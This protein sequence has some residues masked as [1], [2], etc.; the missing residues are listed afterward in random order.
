M[1]ATS[2]QLKS[3]V[4]ALQ[5]QLANLARSQAK[6]DRLRG[7]ASTSHKA[8]RA[9][10]EKGFTGLKLALEILH[11]YYAGDQAHAGGEG[12]QGRQGRH[13]GE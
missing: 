3:E 2:A 4:A 1:D 8:A 5:G 10:W 12:G 7:E 9:D 6:M 13:P 11:E